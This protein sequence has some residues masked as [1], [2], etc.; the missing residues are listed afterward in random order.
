M[1]S[2]TALRPA[3]LLEDAY[4][5][6]D[7]PAFM[8]HPY[9]SNGFVGAGPFRLREFVPGS[10]VVLDAFDQYVLGR[11]KID[12]LTVRFF[13]DVNTMV[14]NI[15]AGTIE[16]TFS[17]GLT[18]AQAL[19][20][21]EHW[22]AGTIDMGF[23]NWFA[24]WPQL[25]NPDP[26]VMSDLRFRRALLYSIDRQGIV[27]NLWAGFTQVAHSMIQPS[28]PGFR[29][30]IEPN[31]VRYDYDVRRTAALLEDLGY[32]RGADGI[33]A[34]AAGQAPRIQVQSSGGDEAHDQGAVVIVDYFKQAGIDAYPFLIPD[35][36]RTNRELI[37]T[38]PGVGIWRGAND[39]MSISAMHSRQAAVAPPWMT[40]SNRSRYT[41]SEFDALL[42][43]YYVTISAN[44]R[45][46][47]LGQVM[48]HTTEQLNV[49]PLWYNIRP[50][51]IGKR[52]KNV[53][54]QKVTRGTMHW[55]AHE[56][57]VVD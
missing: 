18:M 49:M 15:L 4:R 57:D 25:L 23:D 17:R 1:T 22:S 32:R 12:E 48:R 24:L 2:L 40:A 56:W 11:P 6:Q 50:N 14:A 29:E 7:N 10:H 36:Q 37:S 41:N 53:G 44:E 13:T 51:A 27:D 16:L 42:D 39:A 35:A 20:L 21:S 47:L 33:F 34:D 30:H 55:N 46:P 38:F 19:Q 31:V 8:Q 5:T 54:W 3:H 43:R 28:E 9:W 52:L 45:L 26:P